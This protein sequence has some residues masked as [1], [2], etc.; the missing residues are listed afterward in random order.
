MIKPIVEGT[1]NVLRALTKANI[2]KCVVVTSSAV[3]LTEGVESKEQNECID[4]NY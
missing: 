3:A 1:L 2:V 4:E